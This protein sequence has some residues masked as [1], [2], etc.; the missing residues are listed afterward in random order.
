MA[1]S[2]REQ[3]REETTAEIKAVARTQMAA[4]GAAALSLR[5]I[6]REMGM[7]TPALYRYFENRDALVTALIIDAYRS[8][9]DAMVVADGAVEETDFYGRF[10]AIAHT[11]REWAIQYPADFTLIYGTP[12]P[13]YHA[14]GELTIPLAGRI[15]EIFGVIFATA[16]QYGKLEVPN[17]YADLPD[18]MAQIIS[19]LYQQ[20]NREDVS[21][22]VITLTMYTLPR[23]YGLVWAEQYGHF[24]LGFAD[25]GYFYT[26]EIDAMCE[27]F[28][29]IR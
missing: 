15:L 24:P 27:H 3:Q 4:T 18:D 1:K 19:D 25:S 8:L 16:I 12:I 17:Q 21:E 13:G 23:V 22:V 26:L 28:G 9:G 2:R 10:Q 6:A 14:P 7:S 29:L 5:A 20:L 11:F